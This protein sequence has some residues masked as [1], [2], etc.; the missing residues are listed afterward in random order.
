MFPVMLMF[1]VIPVMVVLSVMTMFPVIVL[2]FTVTPVLSVMIAT[3][4]SDVISDNC[5]FSDTSDTP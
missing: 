2:V 3:I 4:S 1:S 5:V